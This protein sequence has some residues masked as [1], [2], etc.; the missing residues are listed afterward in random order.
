MAG[1]YRKPDRKLPERRTLRIMTYN[2]HS[3]IGMDGKISP[4]RTALKF[5]SSIPTWDLG[6]KNAGY[7]LRRYLETTGCPIQIVA[8]RSF[9]VEI[10][11]HF[12]FPMYAAGSAAVSTMHRWSLAI[13]VQ[14]IPY[15]GAIRWP[16]SIT[17]L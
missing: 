7:R 9:W 13:I 6:Q 11:T 3:C 8:G 1:P 5:S 4:E 16:A 17:Y 15:L 12:P 14:E 10:S 2:I